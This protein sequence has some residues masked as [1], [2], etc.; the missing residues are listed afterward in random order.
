M[1]LFSEPNRKSGR[2]DLNLRPLD[3]QSS[4]GYPATL[5]IS[6]GFR[7]SLPGFAFPANLVFD[8]SITRYI[9]PVIG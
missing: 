5:G 1:L 4:M 6:F 7:G 9:Q 3:P 8:Y 2:Q